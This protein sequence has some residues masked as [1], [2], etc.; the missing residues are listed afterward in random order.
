MCLCVS[1]GVMCVCVVV[2][3]GGGGWWVGGWVSGWGDLQHNSAA[4]HLMSSLSM[5]WLKPS[6][7]SQKHRIVG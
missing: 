4:T 2:V 6:S 1:F 3:V 5:R 7:A